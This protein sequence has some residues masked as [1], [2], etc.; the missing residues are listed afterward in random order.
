VKTRNRKQLNLLKSI[1][2]QFYYFD[3]CLSV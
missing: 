3:S 2:Q 1:D